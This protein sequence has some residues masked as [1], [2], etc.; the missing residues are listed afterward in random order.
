MISNKMLFDLASQI[1]DT[2]MVEL[3]IELGFAAAQT[4]RFY[5]TNQIRKLGNTGGTR[6]LLFKWREMVPRNVQRITLKN[7]L[8]NSGLSNL[9]EVLDTGSDTAEDDDEGKRNNFVPQLCYNFA[10]KIENR[11]YGRW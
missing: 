5:H 4:N 8:I 10:V 2:D 3:G 1:E 6:D 11:W 9:A 7:A